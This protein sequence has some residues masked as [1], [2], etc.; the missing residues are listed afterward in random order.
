MTTK[1]GYSEGTVRSE[2]LGG[3]GLARHNVEMATWD[4]DSLNI[5]TDMTMAGGANYVN[6]STAYMADHG[7]DINTIDF[8]MLIMGKELVDNDEEE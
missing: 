5:T 4:H 8:G 3:M 6:K 2:M 1:L 7:E